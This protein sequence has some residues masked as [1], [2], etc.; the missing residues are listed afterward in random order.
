M[1]IFRNVLGR[2]VG[3]GSVDSYKVLRV[4]YSVVNARRGSSNFTSSETRLGPM[5]DVC[6]GSER[7]NPGS[8]LS[9]GAG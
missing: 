7:A 4:K 3:G 5:L 1:P 2:W 9:R 8:S 6:V